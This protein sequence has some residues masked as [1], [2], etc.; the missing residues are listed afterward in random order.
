MENIDNMPA[1]RDEA[2][3]AGEVF[4]YT[5]LPC[6]RGHLS[7]RYTSSGQCVV[8]TNEKAKARAKA[9]SERIKESRKRRLAGQGHEMAL[10]RD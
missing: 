7:P 4:Y 2:I 10:A 6:K 5:G 3:D 9:L 1:S 8:C